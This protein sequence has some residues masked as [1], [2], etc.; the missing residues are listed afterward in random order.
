[1]S[2]ASVP[3]T[4][5]TAPRLPDILPKLLA[6]LDCPIRLEI[7]LALGPGESTQD[8]RCDGARD[9]AELAAW[10]DVGV[11][12]VSNHLQRLL[13]ENLVRCEA[14]GRH[15]RY[16]LA[17]GVSV[18]KGTTL[19]IRS[20]HGVTITIEITALGEPARAAGD[21]GPAVDGP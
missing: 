20:R 8:G 2:D 19:S 17:A 7:V 11:T 21:H 3:A 1:M 14:S 5:N 4:T 13:R 9:V 10:L 15:R 18:E 16:R 12:T 6:T